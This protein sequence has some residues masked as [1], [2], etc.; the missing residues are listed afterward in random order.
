LISGVKAKAQALVDAAKGVISDAIQAAKNLLGI[1][2]PS[3]VFAE[4]GR[5]VD[6]GFVVGMQAYAGRVVNA[7]K[8]LGRSAVSSMSNVI[9]NISDVIDDNINAQPT[10]RP[11]LDL[12]NVESGAG[13]INSMLSRTRAMAVSASMTGRYG[14]EIQNGT[15]AAE[16]TYQ[17]VQNNYSPKPLSSL[18]IY[19]QTQNQLETLKG[20]VRT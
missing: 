12:T 8:D 15:A 2:S 6:E 10:I 20:L 14:S 18:E 3:R 19:R 5:Y 4:M 16:A 13:R 11:V 1:K 9:K 17:F 7:T